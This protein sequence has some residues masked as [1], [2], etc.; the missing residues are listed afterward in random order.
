MTAGLEDEFGADV[1]N[2]ELPASRTLQGTI[3]WRKRAEVGKAG[4]AFVVMLCAA[5]GCLADLAMFVHFFSTGRKI[6]AL[7][8]AGGAILSLAM[9]VGSLWVLISRLD[10]WTKKQ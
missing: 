8:A 6:A 3:R 2:I 9:F 10:R 4:I 5:A 7:G 1:A